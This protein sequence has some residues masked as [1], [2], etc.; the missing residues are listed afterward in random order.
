MRGRI[1]FWLLAF[2]AGVALGHL[3]DP[4]E[5]QKRL[6]AAAFRA[7]K[8]RLACVQRTL[9]ATQVQKNSVPPF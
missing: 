9:L 3:M 5:K 2:A 6:D 1:V 4:E 8:A 7:R